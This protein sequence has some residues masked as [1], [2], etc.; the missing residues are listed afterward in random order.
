MYQC[1]IK[2][3]SGWRKAKHKEE[4]DSSHLSSQQAFGSV[5]H[6]LH[7]LPFIRQQQV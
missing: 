3:M 2:E 5:L 4:E 7:W 1:Q 6:N